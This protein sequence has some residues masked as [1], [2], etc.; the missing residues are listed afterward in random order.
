MEQASA[1]LQTAE[2][3]LRAAHAESEWFINSVPSIL[4]GTDATGRITRWN[5]AATEIFGLAASSVLG[6][7][8]QECGVHW[9]APDSVKE[10]D[11]WR[12]I[13]KGGRHSELRF[14]KRGTQHVLGLTVTRITFATQQSGGLLITRADITERL[15]LK[16]QVRQ[17]QKLEA[18][19]QLAAGI[20][21]EINTPTQYVLDNTTYLK[22]SWQCVS[23]VLRV[24]KRIDRE[25]Q[26]GV[27]SPEALS[28]LH[29]LLTQEPLDSLLEEI[30]KAIEQSL[31][32]PAGGGHRALDERFFASRRGRK[33]G[34]EPKSGDRD[35][36]DDH[37]ERMEARG[38]Y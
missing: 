33:N 28:R 3:A 2:Q 18:V 1:T 24:A 32:R 7:S 14:E 20:A 16:M 12:Q 8:L 31:G 6:K 15:Q 34:S 10:I 11:S 25:A 37:A 9:S 17:A 22:E 19:G 29:H 35:D 23:A 13:R 26:N 36:P 4:I 5:L 27:A 21:H 38:R 30:P